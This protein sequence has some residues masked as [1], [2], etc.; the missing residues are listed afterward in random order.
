[1]LMPKRMKYRK[2]H[3]GRM[4]ER[5]RAA[6]RFPSATTR[7]RLW[8]QRGFRAARSMAARRAITRSVRRG[9]KLW[10]RI[11][12]DHPV[13]K[14]AAET[15]MGSGKGAVDHFAAVV[16]PGRILF[17]MSACPADGPRGAA[18]GCPQAAHQDADYRP[19]GARRRLA[20]G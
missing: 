18:P 2:A 9:G 14:R 12:P 7:S 1:M 17:E 16:K 15:R 3:R 8:S 11:F 10:I 6:S 5:R 13:T 19:A 20:C 4:G